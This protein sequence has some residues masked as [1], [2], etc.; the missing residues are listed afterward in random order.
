M[1][2]TILL[3]QYQLE[4]DDKVTPVMAYLSNAIAWGDVIVKEAIRVSTWLRT[5][6]APDALCLRNARYLNSTGNQMHKPLF[7]NE[8]HIATSQI[9]GFHI[10]PPANDPVDYDP[11]EGFRKMEPMTAIIGTSRFD[12]FMRMATMSCLNKYI[13]ITHESF[14]SVYDATVSNISIL[15][16]KPFKVPLIIVRQENT[17]FASR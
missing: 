1:S 8:L 12:G 13:E 10:I 2:E 17:I 3:T 4:P 15:D 6:N 5:N 9:I 16:L 11:T 7:F 14:T